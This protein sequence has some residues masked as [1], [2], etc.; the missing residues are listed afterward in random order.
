MTTIHIYDNGPDKPRTGVRHL[1]DDDEPDHAEH[2]PSTKSDYVDY[3]LRNGD[4]KT[5]ELAQAFGKNKKAMGTALRRLAKEGRI[6]CV[7]RA[8]KDGLP[9]KPNMIWRGIA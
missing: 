5:S 1:I 3:L 9:G 4:T 2:L 8:N 7:G 6:E